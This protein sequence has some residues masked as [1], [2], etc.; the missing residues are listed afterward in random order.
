[1]RPSTAAHASGDYSQSDRELLRKAH[2]TIKKVTAD[3]ERFHF[4][5]AVSAIMELANAMQ[6]Y[7][8]AHGPETAAYSEAAT[9]L[10]LLL[11]PMAPHISEELWH[12]NGGVG[13][14]HTQAWAVVPMPP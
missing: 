1:M 7:R 14:I 4:N 9:G 5:T 3:I 13:S 6:D 10:L 8:D 2:L 11:A 12:L